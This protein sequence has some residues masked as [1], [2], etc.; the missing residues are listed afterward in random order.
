MI[1]KRTSSIESLNRLVKNSMSGH[2]GIEFIEMGDDHLIAKM[3]VHEKTKQPLGLLHGGASAALAETLGSVASVLCTPDNS[4]SVVGI[5]I[6]S[7]H[8][9]AVKDGYVWAKVSPIKIGK[10]LHL[11]EI[12]M[13]DKKNQLCCDSRLTVLVKV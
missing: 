8:L 6:S 7:K 4:T 2:L 10:T 3:P 9:R 12:K 1:W 11:W 5:D 13:Y